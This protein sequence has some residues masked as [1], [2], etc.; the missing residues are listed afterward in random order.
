MT[1]KPFVYETTVPKVWVDHN[2]HMNDTEYSRAFSDANDAWIADLGLTEEK[3]KELA[4]TIFTLETHVAYLKEVFESENI[5]V[6]THL[7]DYDAKRLHAFMILFNEA[8]E[9]CATY[10]IM[11][12]GMDTEAGRPAPFPD[13]FDEAV[14]EYYA[15]QSDDVELKELGSK[16]GIRR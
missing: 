10:E 3:I 12:M 14:K 13:H 8:G 1:Q 15:S 9:R 16:I 7:Y 11:S 6:Q 2:G 5:K 4:Y